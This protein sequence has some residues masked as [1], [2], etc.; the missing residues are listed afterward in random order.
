VFRITA[1]GAMTILH[2]FTA[3]EGESPD[4]PVVQ[5]RDGNFYG[6]TFFGGASGWGTV[7]RMTPSGIVTVLYS[8]TAGADGG[9]PTGA[10]VEATDGSLYGTTFSGGDFFASA[11]GGGTVFRLSP[12]GAETT[13]HA[14]HG[15][16]DGGLPFYGVT[17]GA[18]G[19]IY[20]GSNVSVFRVAPDGSSFTTLRVLTYAVEGDE[21]SLP[22]QAA[23]GNLYL[24]TSEGGPFGVVGGTAFR[25]PSSG[26]STAVL[27]NFSG[28]ADG[29]R[30]LGGVIQARDGNFYGTTAVGGAGFGAIRVASPAT[31]AAARLA[32]RRS[33]R[34]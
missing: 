3:S 14:F 20:G 21:T 8:F 5:G 15:G 31:I 19:S 26:G 17:L 7:Y 30:A 29:G 22:T 1:S 4:G 6:T 11:F 28:G 2:S 9:A 32:A 33:A 25:L 13:V 16:S 34:R 27:H 18:D 24:T 12:S 10:I 23:D